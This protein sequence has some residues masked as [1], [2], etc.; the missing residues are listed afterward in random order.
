MNVGRLSARALTS[1]S[2]REF[3]QER[4]LLDVVIV[5]R[6]SDTVLLSKNIRDFTLA[7]DSP[8]NIVGYA[9]TIV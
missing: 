6:S 8:R 3:I 5:E 2:I 9:F 7:Y 1:S 4:N